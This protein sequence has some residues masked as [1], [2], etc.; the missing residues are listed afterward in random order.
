MRTAAIQQAAAAFILLRLGR[1]PN[2]CYGKAHRRL[3]ARS[4]LAVASKMGNSASATQTGTAKA[5]RRD[6]P[7]KRYPAEPALLNIPRA[8]VLRA[9]T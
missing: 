4:P 6:P 3:P 8:R 7:N 1:S 9:V 2:G 5:E